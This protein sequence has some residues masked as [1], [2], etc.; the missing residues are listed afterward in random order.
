LRLIRLLRMLLKRN[1][2]GRRWEGLTI[3][4]CGKALPPWPCHHDPR[5]R[6]WNEEQSRESPVL[7][8][9]STVDRD[10]DRPVENDVAGVDHW[11]MWC[12]PT[13]QIV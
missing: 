2:Q 10:S 8:S 5:P 3:A 1:L 11:A 6:V 7:P 9:N 12:S 13:T 4:A